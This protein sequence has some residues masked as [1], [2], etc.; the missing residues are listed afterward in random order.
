MMRLALML[1]AALA[2]AACG[3]NHANNNGHANDDHKEGDGHGDHHGEAVALGTHEFEGGW[4]V[5]VG[6]IGHCE[7]GK[8]A[9][10]EVTVKKDGQVQKDARVTGWIG[11]DTGTE[12]SMIARGEWMEKEGLS[13]LHVLAPKELPAEPSLWV[14]VRHGDFDQRA[15]FAVK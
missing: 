5:E 12:L 11:D 4:L 15:K 2:L 13:D 1:V 14:R 9:I 8:E 6:Q 7:A 10:F 3:D